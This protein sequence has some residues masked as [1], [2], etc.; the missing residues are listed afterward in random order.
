MSLYFWMTTPRS[1]EGFSNGAPEMCTLACSLGFPTTCY[2]CWGVLLLLFTMVF[3]HLISWQLWWYHS[4]LLPGLPSGH[5]HLVSVVGFL[6][7]HGSSISVGLG[8]L[9]F[10]PSFLLGQHSVVEL[11]PSMACCFL[12]TGITHFHISAEHGRFVLPS[13][14]CILWL[15]LHILEVSLTCRMSHIRSLLLSYLLI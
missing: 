7:P 8:V 10:W 1:E 2:P 9:L 11:M 6:L 4:L 14:A 15:L 13:D 5:F 12:C 3:F